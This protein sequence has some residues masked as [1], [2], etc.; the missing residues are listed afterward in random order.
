MKQDLVRVVHYVTTMN[1]AGQETLLMNIYRNIDHTQLQ[2]DFLCSSPDIG[3]YD[4]EIRALGG[5]VHHLQQG[6]HAH[7]KILRYFSEMRALIRFFKAN[8]HYKIF[9]IHTYHAFNGFISVISAKLAGVK[10]VII[11]SHNSNAPHPVLHRV[12]RTLLNKMKL[13]FFACSH[14]AGLWMYGKPLMTKNKV[15][16]INNGVDAKQFNYNPDTRHTMRSN[17]GIDDQTTVV[18]HIGRFN[19]QKNH[20]FLI[21][22]FH[23]YQKTNSNAVLLLVG[24]GELEEKM[25]QKVEDLG[26]NNQVIFAGVRSD[27]QDLYQAMDVFVLPSQFEGLPVVLVE[28]QA[29]GLPC[30]VSDAVTKEVEITDLVT[31]LSLNDSTSLWAETIEHLSKDARTDTFDRVS[32]SGYDITSTAKWLQSFYLDK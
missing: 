28:A 16:I 19:Y 9:H 32:N 5:Q 20:E 24:R 8:R 25:K 7:T 6:K 18:G 15:K 31:F 29:A 10:K 2:F 12:F 3:D 30:L 23:D 13:S 1:R 21:D 26:L 22:I 17:L 27:T 14:L 4:D 11:H